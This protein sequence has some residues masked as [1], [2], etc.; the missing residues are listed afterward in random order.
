MTKIASK[1]VT[2]IPPHRA[3]IRLGISEKMSE[4]CQIIFTFIALCK[5]SRLNLLSISF[6]P[7]IPTPQD[8]RNQR[9]HIVGRIGA[10][11]EEGK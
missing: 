8:V 2:P 4:L 3:V 5:T 6:P 1:D 11:H 9:I 7:I 10:H